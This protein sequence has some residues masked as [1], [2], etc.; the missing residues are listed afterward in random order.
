MAGPKKGNV[1]VTTTMTPWKPMEVSERERDN[2]RN[3]GLLDSVN[4][5]KVP[6]KETAIGQAEAAQKEGQ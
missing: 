4:G 6:K 5:E 1:M 2:L 3:L